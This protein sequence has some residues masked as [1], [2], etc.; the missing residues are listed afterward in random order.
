LATENSKLRAKAR[1]FIDTVAPAHALLII[2][3]DSI[4]NLILTRGLLRFERKFGFG[5][6]WGFLLC[7]ILW[8]GE[9]SRPGQRWAAQPRGWAACAEEKE[10]VG[11]NKMGWPRRKREAGQ[12]GWLRKNWV[13]THY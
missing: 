6:R 13:S 12:L 2:E 11:R 10:G 8:S 1:L 3:L 9:G 7:T 4:L 5:V